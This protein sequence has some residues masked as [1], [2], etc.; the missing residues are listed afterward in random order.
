MAHITIDSNLTSTR[1]I[2]DRYIILG[3]PIE[4]RLNKDGCYDRLI[5]IG[6]RRSSIVLPVVGIDT[7]G[8]FMFGE[9][10]WTELGF[11]VKHVEIF[12]FCVV[13]DEIDQDLFLVMGIGA[14]R[15]IGALFYGV[16]I[17][18]TKIFLVFL[19]MIMFLN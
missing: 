17:V 5:M 18:K 15:T 19:F 1:I 13:M 11:I 4:T 12:I 9:V 16:R 2:R 8:G 7:F 6:I 3:L 14:E 10:E